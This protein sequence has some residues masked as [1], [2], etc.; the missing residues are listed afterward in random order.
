MNLTP[1]AVLADIE[2]ASLDDWS[3]NKYVNK[4]LWKELPDPDLETCINAGKPSTKHY[5]R[6]G[7]HISAMLDI[8]PS[9]HYLIYQISPFNK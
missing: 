7:A 2:V 5:Y 1:S 6:N 4:E 3:Y 8:T 9:T